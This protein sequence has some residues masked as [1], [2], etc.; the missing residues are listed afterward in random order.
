MKN[1]SGE[2]RI[3]RTLKRQA[4]DRVAHFEW[5][6]D[7]KVIN[8][9]SPGADYEKFCYDL[10]ID[11]ICVDCDFD[12]KILDGGLVQ[13]EWKMIKKYTGEAHAFPVD[14]PIRTLKDAES[15]IPPDPH[16]SGRYNS[17]ERALKEHTGKKA[18]ILH[19]NDVFS[20][21]S[22]LM[23]FETFL[24]KMMEDPEIIKALVKMSVD[25]NLEMAKE[26]VKRGIK[27]VYTGDDFAYNS[28]PIVSPKQFRDIFY[29][30]L[31]R[32]VTGY[33][34]LGLIVIKHTDGNIMPIIDM[35]IDS[36]F[37]CL[38]PID[39]IAGM[40]LKKIKYLY[41]DKIC[42]KGNVDCS[43]TLSFKSIDETIKETRNCLEIAMSGGGYILSSSNSIH[44]AVKPENYKAMIDTVK[45]YGRY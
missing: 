34:E 18:V 40:D 13:D 41:G 5:Y 31:K 8:A 24:I 16:K 26:A 29:P 32:V 3:M 43:T 28:G 42:I 21:P 39:P 37:D 6:I 19:L 45:E 2:E 20:I 36:G 11:A 33:K 17:I 44:S 35:I 30:E 14:G 27:I 23:P 25:I 38:D 10:D 15:Y 1:L 22:R 12:K 4:T 9:L 7:K